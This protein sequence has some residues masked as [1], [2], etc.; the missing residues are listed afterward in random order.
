MFE[1]GKNS[2]LQVIQ[3]RLC[4]RHP[5]SIQNCL[6]TGVATGQR[7]P[8]HLAVTTVAAGTASSFD[9]R[10]VQPKGA[11]PASLFGRKETTR[12]ILKPSRNGA[13]ELCGVVY[14]ITDLKAYLVVDLFNEPL[15]IMSL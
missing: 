9:L 2:I 15:V 12:G 8:G 4:P 14:A 3:A 7:R 5:C 1:P 10:V 6:S 11:A 13:G